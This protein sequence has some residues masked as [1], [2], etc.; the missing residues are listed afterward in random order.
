MQASQIS[1]TVPNSFAIRDLLP[2]ATFLNICLS[3]R[4]AIGSESTSEP[5]FSGMGGEP[6]AGPGITDGLRSL[7]AAP[8]RRPHD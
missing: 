8:A 2:F 5:T 7:S 6:E 1:I 4:H 3:N